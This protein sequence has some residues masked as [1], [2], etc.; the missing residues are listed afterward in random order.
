MK[1]ICSRLKN[2]VRRS[3][4]TAQCRGRQA[5]PEI[6]IQLPAIDGERTFN[7]QQA[8]ADDVNICQLQPVSLVH[9]FQVSVTQGEATK[10]L[11]RSVRRDSIKNREGRE[12]A[13]TQLE[14]SRDKGNLSY[15]A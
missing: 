11:R 9:E 10:A 4:D 3:G 7:P 14:L 6:A 13:I 2:P 8:L 15:F 1:A 5:Q 12:M